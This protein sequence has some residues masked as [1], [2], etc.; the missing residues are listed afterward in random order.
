MVNVQHMARTISRRWLD[1]LKLRCRLIVG[2]EKWE[3]PEADS[4]MLFLHLLYAIKIGI[5]IIIIIALL[6]LFYLTILSS[7][8]LPFRNNTHSHRLPFTVL[9]YMQEESCNV[10]FVVVLSLI[11]YQFLW[12]L[13]KHSHFLFMRSS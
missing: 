5:T 2:R 3:A 8:F 7:L 13:F 1:S 12:F 10:F 9:H 11:I 6:S 4:Q